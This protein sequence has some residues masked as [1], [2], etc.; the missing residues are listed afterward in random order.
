[1]KGWQCSK[2]SSARIHPPALI[3][4]VWATM[5]TLP[6]TVVTAFGQTMLPEFVM[7]LVTVGSAGNPD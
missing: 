4:G 6:H 7:P 5:G 1:L 2:T 3:E